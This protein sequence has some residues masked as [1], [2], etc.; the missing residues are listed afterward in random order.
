MRVGLLLVWYWDKKGTKS[1][2]PFTNASKT[3]NEAQLNY[4]VTEQE[5]LDVIFGFEKFRSYLLGT[6]VIVHTNHYA[7]RYLMEKRMRN[8]G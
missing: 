1:F 4:T 5:L 7:L 6:R 8:S 3:L 2:I